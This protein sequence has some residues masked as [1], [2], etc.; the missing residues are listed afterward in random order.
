MAPHQKA[1]KTNPMIRKPYVS[2][3]GDSKVEEPPVSKVPSKG[4]SIPTDSNAYE[5]NVQLSKCHKC[6]RSFAPD[7]I[8][9]H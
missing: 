8:A 1:C 4:Y 5:S 7:R 6:G 9:K 2:K 3:T